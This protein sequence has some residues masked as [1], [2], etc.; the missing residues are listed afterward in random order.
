MTTEEAGPS[1]VLGRLLWSLIGAS[2]VA[3]LL[4]PLLVPPY[5]FAMVG[6]ATLLLLVLFPAF[7]LFFR[8]TGVR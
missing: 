8:W 7:Y 2:V 3:I 6:M 4:T 5:A 1:P